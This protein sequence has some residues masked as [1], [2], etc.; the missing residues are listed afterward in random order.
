MIQMNSPEILRV[1]DNLTFVERCLM[2][3]PTLIQLLLF[4]ALAFF[5]VS[6]GIYLLSLA[7]KNYQAVKEARARFA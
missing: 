5:V 7:S 3:L 1:G 4:A 6:A 2:A